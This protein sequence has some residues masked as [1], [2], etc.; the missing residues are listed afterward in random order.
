MGAYR[1]HRSASEDYGSGFFGDIAE[2]V[3]GRQQ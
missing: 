1:S 2:G 3:G